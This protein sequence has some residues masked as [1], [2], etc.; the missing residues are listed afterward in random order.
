MYRLR[1]MDRD[2]TQMAPVMSRSMVPFFFL[3]P[4][5]LLLL[6][7]WRFK[8]EP[9]GRGGTGP[10][11]VSYV[12]R[13]LLVVFIFLFLTPQNRIPETFWI[14]GFESKKLRVVLKALGQL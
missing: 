10:S 5:L 3:L 11:F 7:P 13:L 1:I 12:V 8:D 9:G 4:C 2:T 6:F 14:Q